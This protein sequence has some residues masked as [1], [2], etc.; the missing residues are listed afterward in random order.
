M[1]W[2]EKQERAIS[3]IPATVCR[4]LWVFAMTLTLGL[5]V[6]VPIMVQNLT[7]RPT[8]GIESP[9]GADTPGHESNDSL[10]SPMAF[11]GFAMIG[12]GLCG[13]VSLAFEPPAGV[14]AIAALCLGIAAGAVH[15][16][17]LAS[18][19]AREDDSRVDGSF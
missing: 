10:A 17:V 9:V 13:L 11:A 6:S 2:D 16:E 1:R 18:L 5:V 7:L 14:A 3:S 12:G 15:P 19:R 4:M 8:S